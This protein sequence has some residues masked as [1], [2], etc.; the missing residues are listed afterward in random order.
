[1]RPALHPGCVCACLLAA[2]MSACGGAPVETPKGE[3][4]NSLDADGFL[5]GTEAVDPRDEA[6]IDAID[7]LFG[8]RYVKARFFGQSFTD[9]WVT[10]DME[11]GIPTYDSAV[12]GDLDEVLA[13]YQEHGWSMVPMLS[14]GMSE[15]GY[16]L[17]S[18]SDAEHYKDFVLWFLRQ[19]KERADIAYIELQNSP[20]PADPR[21][22]IEVQNLIYEAVKDEYPDV[23]VGTPGFEYWDDP[24]NVPQQIDIVEHYLDPANDA[25]FDFWA[26]HGY[27][28]ATL[29]RDGEGRIADVIIHPPTVSAGSN[30]FAG[31]P[32]IAE[33]RR[34]LDANGWQDRPIIDSEHA[35]IHDPHTRALTREEDEE[36]AAYMVQQLLLKRTLRLD[37]EPVL[38]GCIPFKTAPWAP[39]GEFAYGNLH[40]DGSPTRSA[41]AVGLLLGF[42]N[43]YSHESHV[44]GEFDSGEVWIEKFGAR[45]GELYVVFKPFEETGG[46]LELDHQKVPATIR[47]D[48][49]P[50]SITLI[51]MLGNRETLQPSR[52]VE[53]QA[54]NQPQYLSVTWRTS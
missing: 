54:S 29:E 7:D 41:A 28:M 45:A 50:A 11:Y 2:P 3:S 1:M 16:R 30:R 6:T 48:E 44:S 32:G 14:Y 24:A 23:A 5:W 22:W 31:I 53:V 21:L 49:L 35:G 20:A 8:T 42:L 10:F 19:C 37:G 15:E 26:F 39:L 27:Q 43:G 38:A 47:F 51:D 4:D 40:S 52:Q 25:R 36:N 12:R 9:D 33:V 17:G 46:E 34:R 18:S 13:V